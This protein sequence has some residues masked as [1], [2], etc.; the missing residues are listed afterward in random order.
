MSQSKKLHITVIAGGQSAEHEVSLLSMKN[1]VSALNPDKY[2]VSVI[3][4]SEQGEWYYCLGE[5][6]LSF[7]ALRVGK[8][9]IPITL[10]FADRS[11]PWQTEDGLTKFPCD[12]VFP[13]IHGTGGE[14]GTLQGLLELVNI[15]YVGAGVLGTALC[16]DK[17]MAK[18]V[19]RA[20]GLAVLD[21][22]TISHHEKNHF[23]Y[24]AL[25]SRFGSKMFVKPA[26]LGSSVGVSK[27]H[28]KAEF[29]Q[30]INLAFEYDTKILIE[31]FYFAREIECSVLGNE[32]PQASLPGEILPES[33]EFYSYEAKY[34]DA[35]AAKVI[36]PANLSQPHVSK[37]QAMSLAAF[38]ALDCEGM[39][40]VDFF[41]K[42][43]EIV[44]NEL[45]TIPGFTNI[46]M[47]PKNWAVSGISGEELV[48]QLIE[49][50]LERYS[51]RK[52]LSRSRTQNQTLLQP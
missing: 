12:C 39:A 20:A 6:A 18:T 43:D 26:N 25:S 42:D 22:Q 4:I 40:R 27:V 31:P 13:I 24:E 15:P 28:N 35:N 14:D 16:M 2:Q 41:V 48:D 38:K 11:M 44:I 21:W 19:L 51:R 1:V 3:Y 47:Y 45:N 52:A 23:T 5:E 33:A 30:A 49:L 8:E 17:H 7:E 34:L 32:N 29:E 9:L 37:I 50:A 46:S 10:D 36:T